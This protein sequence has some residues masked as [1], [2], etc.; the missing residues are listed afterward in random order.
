MSFP[1][2]LLFSLQILSVFTLNSFLGV[3]EDHKCRV[4][5][6]EGGG[7]AGSWQAGVLSGFIRNLPKGEV[8]YDVISGIS[9]GS[10]NGLY[11]A[12][13]EKGDEENM[14]ENLLTLWR[15]LRKEDVYRPWHGYYIMMVEAF[16]NQPSLFDNSPLKQKLDDYVKGKQLKRKLS[17]GV[18]DAT[19]ADVLIFDLDQMPIENVTQLILDSTS[20]P[21]VFP[22]QTA[23]DLVLMDGGVM[24]NIDVHS[25]VRRCIEMGFDEADIVVDAILPTGASIEKIY[26]NTSYT[27]YDMYKRYKQLIEYRAALDDIIHAINDFP[28][29]N[30]RYIVFPLE[31]IPSFTVPIFFDKDSIEEMIKLGEKDAKAVIESKIPIGLNELIQRRYKRKKNA[32]V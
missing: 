29:V 32:F 7:D 2:F 26:G 9:V 31:S 10:L 28:E 11:I 19:N 15:G 22:Y 14:I 16:F 8:E 30:F 24:M 4:L 20:M 23:N 12:T 27:G 13:F 3:P 21:A 5:C 6:L 17:I 18:T 25:A 1:K